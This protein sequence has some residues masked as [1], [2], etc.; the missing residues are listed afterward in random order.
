MKSAA[1]IRCFGFFI[2]IYSKLVGM[3]CRWKII[4]VDETQ[5]VFKNTNV[6]FVG[7]HSRATM[8]PFFQNKLTNRK[9]AALVSPHQDGQIIAHMLKWFHITPVNGSSNENQRQSALEL[10]RYLIEGHDLFISPDGPRGPRMRMKKS[11]VYYAQKTGKPIVC[12][13]F[14]INK[15]MVISSSWDKT[16]VPIPFAKGVFSLSEPIYIPSD[17]TDEQIE[18]YRLRLENIANAQSEECDKMVGKEPVMP[19]DINDVRHRG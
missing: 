13:C 3:T 10:M 5:K 19:A 11:P 4:G 8:M 12:A 18:E 14:S 2:F 6:I 15:A 9:M 1:V 7:W 17:L 16:M